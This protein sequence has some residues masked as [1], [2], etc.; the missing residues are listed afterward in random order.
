ML[1]MLERLEMLEM[2]VVLKNSKELIGIESNAPE[3]AQKANGSPP[4]PLPL[5]NQRIRGARFAW[6][7]KNLY[8]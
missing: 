6:A 4:P 1:E 5:N 8:L 3:V 2:L 7:P